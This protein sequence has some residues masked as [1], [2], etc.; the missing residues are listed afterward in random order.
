MN[1]GLNDNSL[2]RLGVLV[3]FGAAFGY[4]EAAVVVY[5]RRI[6]YPDGF[7]FPIADF[8]EMAGFGPYLLTEVG[9]EAATLVLI[10]TACALMAR[11]LRR[12]TAYFLIIFAIWD[13]TYYL[14]LK[15]ILNWPASVMDWDILFLIPVTWGGP[16]LAPLIT[17]CLMLL[18]AWALLSKGQVKVTKLWA[19]SFVAGTIL[20]VVVYCAGGL[21]ITD[22]DYKR[23]FSWPAFIVLHT[24]MA[25]LVFICRRNDGSGEETSETAS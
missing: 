21:H 8:H 25:A 13:I 4:I 24:A 5:L 18:I 1:A 3:L 12:R 2:K 9:R 15:V 17:S 6:F 16:V 22:P 14:W 20:I 19:G 11:D 7:G 10:L 23:Y